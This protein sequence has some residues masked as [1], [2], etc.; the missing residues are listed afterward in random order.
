MFM[1][2][3][4]VVLN[5]LVKPAMSLRSAGGLKMHVRGGVVQVGVLAGPTEGPP[6]W[7]RDLV[8]LWLLA[9]KI[10]WVTERPGPGI[11]RSA[12]RDEPRQSACLRPAW[13]KEPVYR[14]P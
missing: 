12:P 13:S 9:P 1:I 8:T 14:Q 11:R 7:R 2:L 4:I 3:T 10:L 6:Y 5:I